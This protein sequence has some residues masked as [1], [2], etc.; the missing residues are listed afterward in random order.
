MS[1]RRIF[2]HRGLIERKAKIPDG[3]G[4]HTI[5]WNPVA[6]IPCYA[7]WAGS[8]LRGE[9]AKPSTVDERRAAV[10]TGTDVVV[11]DRI[12]VRNPIGRVIYPAMV[13]DS[14]GTRPEYMVLIARD[15]D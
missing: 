5:A 6:T 11:G 3:G 13:V 1:F 4:G 7:W 14:V 8:S 12:T 15:I 10:P 2:R 9:G